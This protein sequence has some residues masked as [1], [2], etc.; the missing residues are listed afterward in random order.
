MFNRSMTRS[1]GAKWPNFNCEEH[2]DPGDASRQTCRLWRRASRLSRCVGSTCPAERR[3]GVAVN[4]SF[5]GAPS[6]R[7]DAALYGSQDGRRHGEKY[8][9]APPEEINGQGELVA[10]VAVC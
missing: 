7:Q 5:R 4:S 8:Q 9:H 2:F 6:G 1:F 10:V 3:E